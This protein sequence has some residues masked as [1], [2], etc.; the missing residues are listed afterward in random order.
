MQ[1][2]VV[3]DTIVD[4]RSVTIY[5]TLR[6]T[7]TITIVLASD[8]AERSRTTER[9][10]EHLRSSVATTEEKSVLESEVLSVERTEDIQTTGG[11]EKPRGWKW[12]LFGFGLGTVLTTAVFI[13]I[14]IRKR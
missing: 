14:R 1:K 12:F 4:V 10:R 9:I 2:E 6:E 7:Q 13:F 11:Q 3:H 5:D 8:S